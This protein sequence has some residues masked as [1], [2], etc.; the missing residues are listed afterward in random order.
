MTAM[1]CAGVLDGLVAMGLPA[2]KPTVTVIHSGG[3]KKRQGQIDACLDHMIR[4]YAGQLAARWRG[5]TKDGHQFGWGG[6]AVLGKI[7]EERDGASQ[8][9]MKQHFAE[10]FTEDALL[11]RRAVEGMAYD[12]YVVFH[13]YYI[14]PAPN[15]VKFAEAGYAP[16]TAWDHLKVAHAYIDGRLKLLDPKSV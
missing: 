4:R 2:P 16:S 6:A 5:E 9:T 15:K 10:C 1:A 7:K 8:G 12:P 3:G 11:I 13:V 14:V